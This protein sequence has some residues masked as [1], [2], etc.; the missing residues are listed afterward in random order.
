[1]GQATFQLTL[2][3]KAVMLVEVTSNPAPSV[4]VAAAVQGLAAGL[5]LALAVHVGAATDGVMAM[6]VVEAVE[7]GLGGGGEGGLEGTGVAVLRGRPWVQTLDISNSSSSSPHLISLSSNSP[8]SP[9]S[10]RVR[11]RVPRMRVGVL[12]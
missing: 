11:T 5:G 2:G 1:M 9:S 10:N 8:S 12:G 4:A 6:V 3:C 7:P